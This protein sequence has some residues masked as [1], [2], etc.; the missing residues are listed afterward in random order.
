MSLAALLAFLEANG[1]WIL[2]LW[3]VLEQFIAA[4]DKL[5]ANSTLQL[6]IN[7]G[8]NFLGKFAKKKD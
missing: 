3:L 2:G 5:K 4:N 6:V 8:K 7:L 1:T